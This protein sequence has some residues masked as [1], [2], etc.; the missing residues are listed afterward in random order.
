MGDRHPTRGRTQRWKSGF[1]HLTRAA[2]VPLALAFIDHARR[3][4]GV[5]AYVNLTGDEASDMA[6]IAA[7]YADKTGRRPA[8]AGPVRLTDGS[9]AAPAATTC[10]LRRACDS[11]PAHG[12][13]R[14]AVRRA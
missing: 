12:T 7:F 1:Y 9:W 2:D 11:R 6:E 14:P 13:G 5:G 8:N 4:V 3:E 10:G